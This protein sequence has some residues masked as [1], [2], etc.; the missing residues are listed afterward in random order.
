MG[1]FGRNK[2][3]QC[4]IP[5]I[6]TLR[7]SVTFICVL[8]ITYYVLILKEYSTFLIS[9]TN[10]SGWN[11][12]LGQNKLEQIKFFVMSPPV[13]YARHCKSQTYCQ[14]NMNKSKIT[15]GIVYIV[16]IICTWF[17]SYIKVNLLN[18]HLVY[19]TKHVRA[20]SEIRWTIHKFAWS[21]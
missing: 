15:K 21:R 6:M 3:Y 2:V 18:L 4:S 16:N 1:V 10:A 20:I 9:C 11:P 13:Y 5:Q 17:L 8:H 19:L 12:I 7:W 14:I